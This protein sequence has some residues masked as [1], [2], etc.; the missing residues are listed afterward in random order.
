KK[1]FTKKGVIY[2]IIRATIMWL[3]LKLINSLCPFK[4]LV[5]SFLKLIILNFMIKFKFQINFSNRKNIIALFKKKNIW[6]CEE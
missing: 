4:Q 2:T 6:G 5:R 1:Q 3:N